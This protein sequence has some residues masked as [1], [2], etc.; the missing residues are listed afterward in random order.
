VS[1]D[2]DCRLFGLRQ[3]SL[4]NVRDDRGLATSTAEKIFVR[5][6]AGQPWVGRESPLSSVGDEVTRAVVAADL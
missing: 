6:F 1:L 2:L 3:R 5:Y 4:K